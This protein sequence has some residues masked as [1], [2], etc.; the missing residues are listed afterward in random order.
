[1]IAYFLLPLDFRVPLVEGVLDLTP[2]R[3]FFM[4]CAV[5]SLISAFYF[6]Q[7][8]ESPK[9]LMSK[10][11]EA[12]A[13]QVFREIYA[14]NTGKDPQTYPVSVR[15][16]GQVV[17]NT[18]ILRTTLLPSSQNDISSINAKGSPLD[19]MKMSF[20]TFL[21]GRRPSALHSQF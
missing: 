2:W 12:E 1:M 6:H 4:V 10:G 3:V 7:F 20:G 9:F 14:I 8:P 17:E 15:V 5:P 18:S 13:L 19:A 16:Q 11:R 21:L